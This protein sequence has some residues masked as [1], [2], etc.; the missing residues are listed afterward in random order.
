MDSTHGLKGNA[1]AACT[2]IDEVHLSIFVM[3][4]PSFFERGR[5]PFLGTLTKEKPSYVHPTPSMFLRL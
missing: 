1:A 5:E 3:V 2:Q 4:G